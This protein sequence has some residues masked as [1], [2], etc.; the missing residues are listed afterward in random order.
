MWRAVRDTRYKYIRNY[1]P[2]LP[3]SQYLDYLWRMPAT[4]AW[5]REYRAGNLNE[6]QRRFFEPKPTEELYDLAADPHE[7][8]N[9]ADDPRH[10]ER[11]RRMREALREWILDIRDTGF[12]PEAEMLFRSEG[13]TPYEMARASGKYD[14]ESILKAA[15]AAGDRDPADLPK[16][17]KFLR[18]EDSAIR[19]WGAVGCLA[20][21]EKSKPAIDELSRVLHDASPNVRIAAAEALSE[22]GS[23]EDVLAV[24]TEALD[25]PS[26]EV[27]LH[28]ANVVDRVDEKAR[29]LLDKMRELAGTES[30]YVQRVMEKAVSDLE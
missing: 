2:H 17:I 13:A 23:T 6:I 12:L 4:R 5:E 25:H 16:L 22:L 29:P 8:N 18:D 7:V 9:L 1:M 19:Y 20:L 15:E 11:L 3:Y 27:Q 14:L 21:G 10:A 28:A 30:K 24:L 26:E